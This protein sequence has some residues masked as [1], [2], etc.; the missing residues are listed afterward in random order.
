MSRGLSNFR[1][2]DKMTEKRMPPPQKIIK[3][4]EKIKVVEVDSFEGLL[5]KI[6]D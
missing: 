1:V 5:M 3:V 2:T 4:K 6:S